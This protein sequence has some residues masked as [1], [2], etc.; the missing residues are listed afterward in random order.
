[1]C[2]YLVAE[3][4]VPPVQALK[5]FEGIYTAKY[6]K[7]PQST[8]SLEVIDYLEALEFAIEKGWYEYKKFD[9]TGYLHFNNFNNG[10][11][12][13]IVP[14]FILA[15]SGPTDDKKT[16]GP[17]NHVNLALT[18]LR[19]CGVN[20]I[21][22]LNEEEYD[23]NYFTENNMS[24]VDLIFE[25]GTVP[26]DHVIGMFY[27]HI[28]QNPKP[29]GVH[30]KAGLGRTGTLIAM[31]MWKFLGMKRRAAIAW[32]RMCRPG[33]IQV[34]EQEDFLL[35]IE[36]FPSYSTTKSPQM[37][38]STS[39]A[40][41]EEETLVA[42]PANTINIG[43]ASAPN[44]GPSISQQPSGI[45]K[46][47]TD[48][49]VTR[50]FI[51]TDPTV[52]NSPAPKS[53]YKTETTEGQIIQDAT[54]DSFNPAR[55]VTV[56]P[57]TIPIEQPSVRLSVN[58]QQI[59]SQYLQQS[60]M[61]NQPAPSPIPNRPI[62]QQFSA[63]SQAVLPNGINVFQGS[64]SVNNIHQSLGPR[65]IAKRVDQA[66][67][68]IPNQFTLPR[69]GSLQPNAMNQ[70]EPGTSLYTQNPMYQSLGYPG[71]GQYQSVPYPMPQQQIQQPQFSQNLQGQ[72]SNY[73]SLPTQYQPLS[74]GYPYQVQG[75][76]N[77]LQ[78]ANSINQ[79]KNQQPY[80]Q[81]KLNIQQ[82]QVFS[83]NLQGQGT[84]AQALGQSYLSPPNFGQQGQQSEGYQPNSMTHI[85]LSQISNNAARSV[86]VG[87][88]RVP[89]IGNEGSYNYSPEID[90][91]PTG[92]SRRRDIK[93][94]PLLGKQ[95]ITNNG[96]S[97]KT[98]DPQNYQEFNPTFVPGRYSSSFGP[99]G[100]RDMPNSF[101][102]TPVPEMA[103]YRS[104]R[105]SGV[106][107]NVVN[108]NL[109]IN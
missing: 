34:S 47:V 5:L 9:S 50:S 81:Q 42:P 71:V 54:G 75:G 46:T 32:L 36:P 12:N 91:D 22:R 26:D 10:D 101:L 64:N 35:S 13:W 37:I 45:S 52:V 66:N 1:M 109:S 105:T 33:S 67:L 16:F 86:S 74:Y 18:K 31:Y 103:D 95:K 14:N 96:L 23:S 63:G 98:I 3:H 40:V 19:E 62:S 83:R 70:Q 102:N 38:K 53:I 6:V 73:Q 51:T 44:L 68:Q 80:N 60:P 94:D 49:N 77:P 93:R 85:P 57:S 97:R 29:Y 56:G 61:S 58:P 2:A 39:I 82:P 108:G 25:D 79:N 107:G 28:Q 59:Q 8:Y 89:N 15:F 55:R 88:T 99:T 87:V 69:S 104:A 11:I 20:T 41:R 21:I 72:S 84:L 43:R 92:L 17:A 24:H 106:Q 7:D 4:K 65:D 78:A 76:Q 30:C 27:Y 48:I 90:E 100:S